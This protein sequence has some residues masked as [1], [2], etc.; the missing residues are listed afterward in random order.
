MP[1]PTLIQSQEKV[2]TLLVRSGAI[3]E[4]DLTAALKLQRTDRGKLGETLIDMGVLSPQALL[5][6]LAERLGVKGCL[7]R[8]GLVDPAAV[9]L[10]DREE[11][12]PLRLLPLFNVH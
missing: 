12:P 10:I 4:E 2:G 6:V 8:H 5:D 3:T 9:K 11:A 7:L 1:A